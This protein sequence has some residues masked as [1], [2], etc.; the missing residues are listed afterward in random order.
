MPAPDPIP[1]LGPLKKRFLG[2]T[3]LAAVISLG[4]AAY[5]LVLAAAGQPGEN[6]RRPILVAIVIGSTALAGVT[7]LT[8]LSL[9]KRGHK[10][11]R[12]DER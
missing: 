6:V 3:R 9:R 2:W 11:S 1:P 4:L 12:S 8:L 7:A 5:A 10:E